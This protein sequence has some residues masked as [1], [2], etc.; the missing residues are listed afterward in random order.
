M[1]KI[2]MGILLF[3]LLTNHGCRRQDEIEMQPVKQ[4]AANRFLKEIEKMKVITSS[5][6][7][8]NKTQ[9]ILYGN[10]EA[11]EN[12]RANSNLK[13]GAVLML[14]TWKSKGDA[15]WFGGVVPAEISS[16]EVVENDAGDN[17]RYSRYQGKDLF[18]VQ[19]LNKEFLAKRK[20]FI[21]NQKAA[22][23]P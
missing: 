20:T 19:N 3:L 21:L 10:P 23:M 7:I 12:A 17:Y 8:N 14:F 15:E 2:R 9:S 1:E 11:L 18:A 13:S 22:V 6:D 5:S 4:N 16:L